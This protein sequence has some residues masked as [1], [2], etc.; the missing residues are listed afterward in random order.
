MSVT[1]ALIHE[2]EISTNLIGL[3]DLVK[4]KSS[5]FSEKLSKIIIE[6]D[7][8]ILSSVF[9]HV[10]EKYGPYAHVYT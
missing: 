1:P 9:V 6:E 8:K 4:S 2:T 5:G 3:A 10:W 7:A